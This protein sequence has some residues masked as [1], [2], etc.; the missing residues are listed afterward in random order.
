MSEVGAKAVGGS[1]AQAADASGNVA[2]LQVDASGNL[3]TSWSPLPA[4]AAAIVATSGNIANGSAAAAIP[5]T[6]GKLSYVTGFEITATGA[7]VG[8]PVIATLA[9]LVGGITASYIFAAPAGALIE[10]TPLLVTFPEPI[11]ANAVNTAITLTLPALGNGNTNA[12]VV[13][14]GFQI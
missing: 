7:T 1:V 8:L 10:A 12:A 3:K 5:A 9:G 13:I 6:S 4:G 14:H 2:N 11:P